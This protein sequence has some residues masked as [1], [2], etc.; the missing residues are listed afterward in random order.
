MPGAKVRAAEGIGR[1]AVVQAGLASGAVTA[2]Q[3][4]V[5][6]R[7]LDTVA[8]M[9]GVEDADRAAAGRFLVAQ[10][11]T[12]APRD[13]RAP[14]RRWSRPSPS[15]PS[16]DDP[17]DE[18][19]LERE[20]ARA[21]A[22]AQERERNF[23]TVTR[24]RGQAPG[25]PRARHHRRGDPGAVSARQGRQAPPRVRRLRGH[26]ATVRTPRRRPR[27]AAQPGRRH[28]H[29][30]HHT[31]RDERRRPARPTS[32]RADEH[33]HDPEHDP[34]TTT[35]RRRPRRRSTTSSA[36]S[37][38]QDPLPGMDRRTAGRPGTGPVGPAVRDRP[39]R[40]RRC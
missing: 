38:R 16:E 24:R 40:S 20:R 9:P 11:E 13:L 36:G 17:A 34:T 8:A 18:A 2:D 39:V 12:L 25:D 37:R 26:P 19:A 30:P 35:G 1:H 32:Q 10:C 23:L 21:E 3:A 7:V 22:E 15:T 5:L 33:D 29:P 4:E 14:G 27:R 28:P 6:V 31:D